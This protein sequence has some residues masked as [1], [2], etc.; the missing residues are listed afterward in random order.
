MAVRIA[1]EYHIAAQP[2][3]PFC[4]YVA[5]PLKGKQENRWHWILCHIMT[6]TANP[7][8]FLRPL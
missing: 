3:T 6:Q 2:R 7:V 1:I 4:H 5:L 8:T